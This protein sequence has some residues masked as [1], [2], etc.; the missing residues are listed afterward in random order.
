MAIRTHCDVCDKL[1][2]ETIG[3]KPTIGFGILLGARF[4]Y[5]D[6]GE[7]MDLCA[8]CARAFLGAMPA[9]FRG[10][11]ERG[12]KQAESMETPQ[13]PMR[14]VPT[15]CGTCGTLAGQMPVLSTW[16]CSCGEN[17]RISEDGLTLKISER[18]S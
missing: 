6:D 12:I 17:N 2:M 8:E 7:R 14:L 16:R 13:K 4:T 18:A 11:F 1:V 5:G 9:A 15:K 10:A 3:G